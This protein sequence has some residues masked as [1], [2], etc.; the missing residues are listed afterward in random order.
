M[1]SIGF[2][3]GL[4]A[5]IVSISFFSEIIQARICNKENRKD[6]ESWARVKRAK[7]G[8]V[9]SEHGEMNRYWLENSF[10]EQE[11]CV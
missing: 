2:I 11:P 7:I 1:F 9:Y 5:G 6:I 3:A 8:N 4:L 10:V